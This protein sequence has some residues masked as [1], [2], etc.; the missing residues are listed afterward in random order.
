M[1]DD[2]PCD[3]ASMPRHWKKWS[4]SRFR[5]RNENGGRQMRTMNRSRCVYPAHEQ[6]YDWNLFKQIDDD[7]ATKKK[8]GREKKEWSFDG[9]RRRITSRSYALLLI[10]R[11]RTRTN[12]YTIYIRIRSSD[13]SFFCVRQSLQMWSKFVM[14]HIYNEG[15]TQ[16]VRIRHILRLHEHDARTQPTTPITTPR[17]MI[18]C[19]CGNWNKSYPLRWDSNGK[20]Q[21]I[22]R[23]ERA[24]A[25][26]CRR[27]EWDERSRHNCVRSFSSQFI[28][29]CRCTRTINIQKT[30]TKHVFFSPHGTG[31]H[32][33]SK[34][35][36]YERNT[37]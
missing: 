9:A 13:Y 4:S 27:S 31:K 12:A 37:L 25:E 20:R 14:N 36:V 17:F 1:R 28:T 2:N 5:T 3:S 18:L 24:A 30:H 7:S 6:I 19:D 29:E 22:E 16:A 23:M 35:N 26:R 32:R 11:I 15:W 34:A 21:R 33:Q 10:S 8:D